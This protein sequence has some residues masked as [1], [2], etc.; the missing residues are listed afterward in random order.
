MKAILAR[1]DG[2]DAKEYLFEVPEG[3]EPHKGDLLLVD[4]IHGK[5]LATAT[6]EVFCGSDLTEVALRLGAYFP[7]R[8]VISFVDE[9]FRELIEKRERD[10]I[11]QQIL[12]RDADDLPF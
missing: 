8:R 9:Q 10:R 12:N 2:G 6:V 5:A 4:T 3:M 1:H 7:L 11:V